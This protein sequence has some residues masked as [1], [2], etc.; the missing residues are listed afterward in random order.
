MG[1][2]CFAEFYFTED[3]HH[4][5]IYPTHQVSLQSVENSHRYGYIKEINYKVSWANYKV[6]WAV[7]RRKV[8]C[9]LGILPSTYHDHAILDGE[10]HF[11]ISYVKNATSTLGTKYTIKI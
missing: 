9:I 3:A 1:G 11:D 7:F 10:F 6:S 8:V 4:V 2:T 5:L